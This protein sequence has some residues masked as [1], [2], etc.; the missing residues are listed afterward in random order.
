MPGYEDLLS[1]R[2]C[3]EIYDL[4]VEF[5]DKFLPGREN[6]R[7]REQM[8]HAARSAKQCI[9]EGATQGTSLRGYIKMIGV[10]RGSLEE[11]LKDYEDFA[12]Q[13]SIPVWDKADPRLRE[14]REMV[15][16]RYRLPSSPSQPSSP[17]YPLNYL[18]DLVKRTGYL[19]DKQRKSLEEKFVKEGGYTENLFKRRLRQRSL[20]G[21]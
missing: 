19:L 7:M 20:L 8:I 12:R 10:S 14:M 2:Q 16:G 11:L 13:R 1:Y 17:S 21:K 4:T 15:T 6:L 18:R 5:C 9:A 3:E